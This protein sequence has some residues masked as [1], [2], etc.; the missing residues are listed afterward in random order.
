MLKAK[1]KAIAVAA[2]TH[3]AFIEAAFAQVPEVMT[4]SAL[5]A[6]VGNAAWWASLK[7]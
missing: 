4:D 2:E 3:D 5:E 6:A 7:G 1:L